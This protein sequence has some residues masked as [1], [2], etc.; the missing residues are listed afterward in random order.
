MQS[1]TGLSQFERLYYLKFGKCQPYP[2]ITADQLDEL[3]IFK[4]ELE[5]LYKQRFQ[6]D[7][8]LE[9]FALHEA[10]VVFYIYWGIHKETMSRKARSGGV[11][12]ENGEEANLWEEIKE[13]MKE[14][15]TIQKSINQI[16]DERIEIEK[17][18]VGKS[19]AHFS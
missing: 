7:K 9:S 14:L 10:D 12:E 15:A 17:Q 16:T 5:A 3:E 1:G 8:P 19:T 18:I 4:A 11:K 2:S 13:L 6:K